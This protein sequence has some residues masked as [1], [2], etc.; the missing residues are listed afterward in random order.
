MSSLLSFG[1]IG[2]GQSA[3]GVDA[4]TTLEIALVARESVERQLPV[5]LEGALR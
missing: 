3:T 5:V 4:R 2:A 1:L